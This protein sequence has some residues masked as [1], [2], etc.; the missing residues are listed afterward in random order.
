MS[1]P[2]AFAEPTPRRRGR[3]P[4]S[5]ARLADA[6]ERLLREGVAMLTER[7]FSAVGLD[8][9]LAAV[10]VPKG[11]FYH[12]FGSKAEFGLALV[13]AYAAYFARRLD[14]WFLDESLSPLARLRAFVEDA[15]AGMARFDYRRGCLVGNLGQEISALPE[16]FRDR[17]VAVF[18]DWEA[19]TARCL[20]AAKSAGEIEA[21]A[22]CARLAVFFWIGW[23]G[24]VLR[25][26]LERR[27][28]PL[29]QFAEGF[30]SLIEHPI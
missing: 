18:A 5:E 28:E 3:P 29:D 1:L 27:P 15:R 11:S 17:L 26:K 24:A 22:D 19:R 13:D 21:H 8:E 7:G 2:S 6:C 25:A 30:F 16:P 9:V 4:R 20:E 10:A 12:Y 23:E 14:R